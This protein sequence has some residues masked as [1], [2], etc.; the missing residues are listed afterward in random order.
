[1]KR[2]WCHIFHT[3]AIVVSMNCWASKYSTVT[4][5]YSLYF[6]IAYKQIVK[7]SMFSFNLGISCGWFDE[8]NLK[9]KIIKSDYVKYFVMMRLVYVIR[10]KSIMFEGN[11][12]ISIKLFL[13][14]S[15]QPQN[16]HR[17]YTIYGRWSMVMYVNTTVNQ[18]LHCI[19]LPP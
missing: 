4:L 5:W 12:Q 7:L 2:V 1:M 19:V 13:I 14:T 10:N 9:F 3:A 11:N 8:E 15:V 18:R 17:R 6:W 16:G